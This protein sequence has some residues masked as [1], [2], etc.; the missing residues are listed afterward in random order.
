VRCIGLLGGTFDPVHFGHLRTAVEVRDG[1][2][3]AEVR[4]VPCR[5]PPHREAP[6]AGPSQR[7][8]MLRIAVQGE[9]GLR[10]DERELTRPAPSYTVDTLASLRA[11]MGAIS[12][13]LVIGEDAFS[14]L[15]SWHRAPD[16]PGLA[17][18][19]VV[20]RPG[21]AGDVTAKLADLI[22]GRWTEQPEHLA[23]QPSGLV[24]RHRVTQMDVSATRIRELVASGRS[25][26]Y[27]LPDTVWDFIRD[28]G[29]YRQHSP[30]GTEVPG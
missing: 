17:H 22:D 20:G 12:L 23:L 3:L 27:L 29:L 15:A 24:Y 21:S 18:M 19:V 16:I 14:E 5:V 26:R 6:R 1:L 28:R 8:A 11:E 9:P 7:A 25:P 4:L 30:R 10:V 2:G 13:C